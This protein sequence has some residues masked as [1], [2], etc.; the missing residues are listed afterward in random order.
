ML[1]FF[2][3][4]QWCVLFDVVQA[5]D[6]IGPVW[7]TTKR[8]RITLSLKFKWIFTGLLLSVTVQSWVFGPLVFTV[9]K[10]TKTLENKAEKLT[11][12]STPQRNIS[13][14]FRG[15]SE[16]RYSKKEKGCF[17]FPPTTAETELEH[18]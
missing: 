3:F 14:F 4:H 15:S 18:C 1:F 8:D 13:R 12:T 17:F 16:K 6:C 2:F 11:S 5:C 10:H 9:A 7:M